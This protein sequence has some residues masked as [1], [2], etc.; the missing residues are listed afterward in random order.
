MVN[1]ARLKIGSLVVRG[2]DSL[3][4]HLRTY[5]DIF[6][7]RIFRVIMQIPPVSP[8]LKQVGYVWICLII[9]NNNMIV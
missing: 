6:S 8:S 1:G 9:S 4:S 5:S 7:V 2:F 3:S